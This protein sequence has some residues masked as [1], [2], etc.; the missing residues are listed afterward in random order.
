MQTSIENLNQGFK[1]LSPTQ[2]LRE[3]LKLNVGKVAFSSSFGQEDQV[4]TDMIFCQN[5]SIEVFTLDTG[6]LFEETWEVYHKTVQKYHQKIR[7]YSPQTESVENLVSEKGAFS[8]YDSVGDRKECCHLR[9]VEP[10][11]RAL[12]DVDLWITGLRA[13]QSAHRHGLQ[14]FSYDD[15]FGLIKY[16]PLV[17]WTLEEVEHYLEQ[18]KVPQNSLHQKGFKSIGCAPCTRAIEPGEDIRAGRWWWERSQKECGLHL[19]NSTS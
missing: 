2:G 9:K 19:Q 7:V 18:H 16:N 11:Q 3:I 8:F 12:Q 13:E 5:L 10:L 6:R 17:H 1:S 15:T 4:I 14:L